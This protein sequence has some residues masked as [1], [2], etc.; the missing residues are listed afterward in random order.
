MSKSKYILSHNSIG[1]AFLL[2]PESLEITELSKRADALVSRRVEPAT[3][4]ERDFVNE[5]RERGVAGCRY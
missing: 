3:K 4:E 2:D 1:G 5:C